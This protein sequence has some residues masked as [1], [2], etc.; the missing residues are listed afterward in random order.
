MTYATSASP[1]DQDSSVA[2]RIARVLSDR[3]VRGELTPGSPVRQDHVATEFRASHVPVREAFRKLEAQGLL[4]S[5]PRRGVR[6]APL[7]PG[8]VFEVTEMRAALEVLALR[9]A[10]SRLTSE[11]LEEASKA[12]ADADASD[13]I[14]VWDRANQRFHRAITAPCRMPRLLATIKELHRADARFLFATWKEL[15]WRARSEQEHA[16]LLDYLR[17]RKIQAAAR[18]LK[19]HILE[20]GKALMEHLGEAK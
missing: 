20:A 11:N 12:M 14:S 2:D 18:T 15:D 17:A 7:D 6:V 13:E 10:F 19:L 3:V 4:V 1:E 8:A 5:E 9:H 16:Q